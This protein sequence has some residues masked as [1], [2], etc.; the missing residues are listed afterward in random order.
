[1]T[2]CTTGDLAPGDQLPSRT[3]R[4]TRGD[5]ANFTGVTGDANPI[6]FSDDV[7]RA[8]GLPSIVAHGMLTMGLGA[9]YLT[10]WLGDPAALTKY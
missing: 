5:L 8:A 3:V 1:H 4:L 9:G 6:H 2:A 7:A 10:E